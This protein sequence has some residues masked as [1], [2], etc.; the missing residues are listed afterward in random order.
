MFSG[1]KSHGCLG[2]RGWGSVHLEEEEPEA[3]RSCFPKTQPVVGGQGP[4]PAVRLRV[5]PCCHVVTRTAGRFNCVVGDSPV[6]TATE[7][8]TRGL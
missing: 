5:T 7:G 2:G 1:Y 4:S 6:T 8:L 3:E